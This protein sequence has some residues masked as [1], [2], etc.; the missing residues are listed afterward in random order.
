MEGEVINDGNYIVIHAKLAYGGRNKNYGLADIVIDEINGEFIKLDIIL[1]NREEVVY[2]EAGSKAFVKV[3]SNASPKERFDGRKFKEHLLK[4]FS[5]YEIFLIGDLLRE[6][7]YEEIKKLF[8]EKLEDYLKEAM[9]FDSYIQFYR[10]SKLENTYPHLIISEGEVE[11]EEADDI[12][13]LDC[14]PVIDSI[15]GKEIGTLEVGD[16]ILV[17]VTDTSYQEYNN[18]LINLISDPDEKLVGVIEQMEFNENNKS[19]QILLHFNANIYGQLIVEA[20][21]QLKLAFPQSSNDEEK[22]EVAK[23]LEQEMKEELERQIRQELEGKIRAELEE[24]IK[25]ELEKEI[26]EKVEKE[27]KKKIEKMKNMVELFKDDSLDDTE[28]DTPEDGILRLNNIVIYGGISISIL[29]VA[30]ILIYIV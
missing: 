25:E 13:G 18:Q 15:N 2:I 30:I 28:S 12:I 1:S 29:I 8:R 4:A 21:Y 14:L 27:S 19:H 3:F 24:E 26:R 7:S 10:S 6:E 22:I 23:D 20:E 11:N 5:K 9:E 16:E 17:E